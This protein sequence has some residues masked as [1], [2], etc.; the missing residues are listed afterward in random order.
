MRRQ[1]KKQVKSETADDRDRACLMLLAD[2]VKTSTRTINDSRD[3][4]LGGKIIYIIPNYELQFWCNKSNNWWT[5]KAYRI[6]NSELT[7]R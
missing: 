2:K 1:K 4:F 7:R 5:L 6:W 3:G